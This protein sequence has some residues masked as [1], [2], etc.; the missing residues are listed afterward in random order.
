[1]LLNSPNNPG[2]YLHHG[3]TESNEKLLQGL[4]PLLQLAYGDTQHYAEHDQSQDV[5]SLRVL[6]FNVP[7]GQFGYKWKRRMVDWIK[8]TFPF[9]YSL[10]LAEAPGGRCSV[11][12]Y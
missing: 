5:G 3:L 2:G 9:I 10:S 4:S 6:G 1:M 8:E 11:V 7:I 12:R